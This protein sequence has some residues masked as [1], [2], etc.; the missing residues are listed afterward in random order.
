[1]AERAAETTLPNNQQNKRQNNAKKG[2]R[3]KKR[4]T[5]KHYLL[6]LIVTV[7]FSLWVGMIIGYVVL[8][9]GTL[10]EALNPQSW[11]HVIR[12]VIG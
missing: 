3:S 1:M 12:I 6:L 9:K 8:G 7:I 11:W 2:S 5:W 10:A 4:F